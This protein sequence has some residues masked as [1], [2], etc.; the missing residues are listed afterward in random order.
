MYF[1]QVLRP[2]P[3]LF[4][5]GDT[6]L[7][8]IATN[9]LPYFKEGVQLAYDFIAQQSHALPPYNKFHAAVR[10]S[11]SWAFVTATLRRREV[12]LQTSLI[13]LFER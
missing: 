6:L 13:R 12:D 7:N 10:R 4:D 5:L 8:H 2:R 1:P 9:P 11:Y 3:I